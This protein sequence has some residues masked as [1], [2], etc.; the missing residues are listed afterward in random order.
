MKTKTLE[1][2]D[3]DARFPRVRLKEPSPSGFIHV[4]TEVDARPSF[5]PNSRK[6][7]PLL[8]CY[9]EW[10]RRLE[11]DPTVLSAIVF[12]ALVVPRAGGGSSRGVRD[13]KENLERTFFSIRFTRA[14]DAP[15]YARLKHR[16]IY[17]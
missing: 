1:A 8:A 6:K 9:K 3:A 17:G 12:N 16:K 11:D 14:F 2:A 13:R 4:A 15:G 10:C 5:L 7:R